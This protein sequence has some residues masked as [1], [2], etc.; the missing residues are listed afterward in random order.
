MEPLYVSGT[1]PQRQHEDDAAF[2]LAYVGKSDI[3]LAELARVL[4]PCGFNIEIPQDHV[5]LVC[6]RSGLAY[7]R[8]LTVLNA[9]GVIDPN[10]RGEVQ[11]ILVNLGRSAQVIHPGDRIAQLLI[12]PNGGFRIIH[13]LPENLI[14]TTRGEDGFGSTGVA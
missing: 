8:G 14:Q 2:D 10:Y 6:P 12:V 5:G 1:V 3:W 7:S 9:P 13:C 11:V 4:V